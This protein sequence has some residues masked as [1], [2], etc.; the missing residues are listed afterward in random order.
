VRRRVS[1]SWYSPGA[2][3]RKPPRKNRRLS[4]L[5]VPRRSTRWFPGSTILKPKTAGTYGLRPMYLP[6]FRPQNASNKGLLRGQSGPWCARLHDLGAAGDRSPERPKSGPIP[7]STSTASQSL[8]STCARSSAGRA[9][10]V[11]LP[12]VA[13]TF[14][15]VNAV[16]SW[17]F[18][19]PAEVLALR[20]NSRDLYPL[21]PSKDRSI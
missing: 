18:A 10:W 19:N 20:G 11:K 16:F 17:S 21:L 7:A 1:A 13:P 9:A 14:P 12:S 15:E 4:V 2:A 3:L 6:E 8:N 5:R